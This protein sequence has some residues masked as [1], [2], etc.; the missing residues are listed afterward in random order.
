MPGTSGAAK[1]D[2]KAFLES[3]NTFQTVLCNQHPDGSVSSCFTPD[4]LPERPRRLEL[5]HRY[6]ASVGG[7]VLAS[8]V[9]PRLVRTWFR[10]GVVFEDP[11]FGVLTLN[12][13][14]ADDG[15]FI[16][17]APEFRTLYDFRNKEKPHVCGK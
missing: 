7:G 3:W 5:Y 8:Y 1:H 12:G 11:V 2:P 13:R 17:Y 15:K 4:Y 10:S 16:P 9:W 14:L 6:P